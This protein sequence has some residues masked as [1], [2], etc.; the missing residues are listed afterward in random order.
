MVARYSVRRF[1]LTIAVMLAVFAA[2]ALWVRADRAAAATAATL[3]VARRR[4]SRL[5]CRSRC[6]LRSQT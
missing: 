6:R 1:I 3:T 4:R 5:A 2:V